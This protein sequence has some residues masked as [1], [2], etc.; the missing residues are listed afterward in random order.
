MEF[1]LLG[2]DR[3]KVSLSP[4]ELQELGVDYDSLD[5]QNP[6]TRSILLQLLEQGRRSAG[7]YPRKAKLYIEVFPREDGGCVIYF[8][9][10]STGELTAAGRFLPGTAPEVYAFADHEVLIRACAGLQERYAHRVLHS[11]LYLLEGGYRLVVHPLDYTDNLSSSFLGEYGRYVG[12]GAVLTA[13]CREHGTPLLEE[14]AIAVL[15]GLF[16]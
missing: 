1:S 7:F 16:S 4:E 6:A 15:A 10:L 3:L 9:R 8:T 2:E 13:F 12:R 11:A 5:Y 14:D